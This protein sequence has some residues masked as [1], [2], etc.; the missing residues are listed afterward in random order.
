MTGDS[1]TDCSLCCKLLKIEAEPNFGFE[2]KAWNCWCSFAKPGHLPGACTRYT[3]RPVAC[4]QFKCLWLVSQNLDLTRFDL[5][6][7][8]RRLRSNQMKPVSSHVVLSQ[9]QDDIMVMFAYVDPAYPRAHTEEP[10]RSHLISVANKG[11][12]VVV[13]VKDKRLIMTKNAPTLELTEEQAIQISETRW[14][15]KGKDGAVQIGVLPN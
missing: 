7:E 1:C 9:S 15:R 5:T 10:V 13:V 12:T 4:Q 3:S 14:L 6:P 2:E 11:C 8:L